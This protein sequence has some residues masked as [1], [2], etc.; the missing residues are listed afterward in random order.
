VTGRR[1][2]NLLLLAAVTAIAWWIYR[3]R[4]TIPGLV[5]RVTNPLLETKAAVQ[6]SEHKR[7]EAEAAPVIDRSQDATVAALHEG[8]TKTDVREALGPPDAI[9]EI[10]TKDKKIL[11]RWTY[12][13]A[14]RLIDFDEGRVVSIAVR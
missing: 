4:P 8:M 7:V 13:R 1:I 12:R 3:D 10:R 11:T 9:D 6:E 14:G 2:R 5:D